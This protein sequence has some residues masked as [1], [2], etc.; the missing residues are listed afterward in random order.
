MKLTRALDKKPVLRFSS[1]LELHIRNLL[2]GLALLI[3]SG[4]MSLSALSVGSTDVGPVGLFKM[5]VFGTQTSAASQFALLEVRL[6]RIAIGFMAGWL[7]AMSGAFLQT[8]ARNPLAD[9]GLFGLNQGAVVVIMLVMIL[10]PNASRTIIPFAALLGGVSVALLL[11]WLV[12]PNHTGGLA[13]LLMGLA[14]ETT[15][16]SITSI[17]ILYAPEEISHA[18][19]SWLAGSLLLADWPGVLALTPWFLLSLPICLIL[20]KTLP[21]LDLGEHV[22]MA[23]GDNVRRTRPLILLGAVLLSAAAVTAV[24][25]LIFLGVMA[26]HL[27]TA[28]S[29]ATGR[30]KLMLSGLMGG[31][32][33]VAADG[34]TRSGL[35]GGGLPVGLSLTIIGVPL[36]IVALRLRALHRQ[37]A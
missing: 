13:I 16:S 30:M 28:I 12:G 2:A 34:L 14:L 24:G 35:A 7:I 23:I 1:G 37:R 10:A 21:A 8:L 9:P 31:T 19:S 11:L 22:A 29:P 4:A 25:P 3:L 27:A 32:L 33:V 26:P 17:M 36:F 5:L 20:G 6:P 15:L 18:L